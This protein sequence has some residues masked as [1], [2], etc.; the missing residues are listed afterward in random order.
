MNGQDKFIEK[1]VKRHGDRY[2]YSKVEYVNST[3]KV[4]I[5]CPEHG[6]FWQEPAAHVRGQNCPV[7]ANINRGRTRFSQED[8]IKRARE[9]HGNKYDYSKVEYKNANTKVC[10]ICSKHGEFWQTPLAHLYG[11]E[12]CPKCAGKGLNQE[13]VIK[14]FKEIHGDKYDYS[15]VEFTKMHA[16]VCIICP[17]HGEFW[18]TPEKHLLGQR[19][20]QCG[21]EERGKKGRETPDNFLK[22]AKEV[23]GDRY[24]FTES[25]YRTM[26]EKIEVICKKHG[27]FFIRPYDLLNGHGCPKCANIESKPE[28][29]IYEYVCELIGKDNVFQRNRVVLGNGKE[30][31]VYVPSLGLG[32]EYNGLRWHTEDMGKD[33]HYH[34]EKTELCKSK[35]IKLIQIFEDEYLNHKDIVFGKIAHIMGKMYNY[36]KIMARKC[37]ITEISI[38][39]AKVFLTENHI[40]GYGKAT[41]AFGAYYG[42]ILVGVMTFIKSDKESEWILNRF[43]TDNKMICSGI[44][45]KLFNHFVKKYNPTNVKS[46]ADR[47]WTLDENNNLYTKIGFK[48]TEILKPDYKYVDKENP[49]ERI[50]KF[51]LRKKELHRK[52]DFDM[53]MTESQMVKEL[54]LVKIW[55]CGLYKYEWKKAGNLQVK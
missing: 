11:K 55:D 32:I 31:D 21:R 2:D 43:A 52:H 1:A 26:H 10:I 6:E 8:F 19:C 18:Q 29:E 13:E 30:I 14:K 41:V 50:H 23:W 27:R 34:L 40:Q 38:E 12:G 7:C 4:C 37:K 39:K 9:I 33:R 25:N 45:G 15:K 3:T 17:K 35:G 47:R 24:I 44:G 49:T 51:N 36:P 28:N 46:F 53:D 54:G 16:K 42:P 20:P 48:L 22:R 5:I